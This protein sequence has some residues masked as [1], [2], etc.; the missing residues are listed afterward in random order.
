MPLM[1]PDTAQL[2]TVALYVIAILGWAVGCI[3]FAR[4]RVNKTGHAPHE[5]SLSRVSERSQVWLYVGLA[6][7]VILAIDRYFWLNH[8]LADQIREIAHQQGWYHR[9][10]KLQ[11]ILLAVSTILLVAIGIF[12][13]RIVQR[14]PL[15]TSWSSVMLWAV[16]TLCVVR[17]M[18]NHY[19]DRVFMHSTAGL[20]VHWMIEW[21]LLLGLIFCLAYDLRSKLRAEG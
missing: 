1:S 4:I 17:A 8:Y 2:V 10:R 18:S 20:R 11:A 16:L 14:A 5:T 9:R 12:R 13:K 15:P 7:L 6:V 3:A 19:V 21:S